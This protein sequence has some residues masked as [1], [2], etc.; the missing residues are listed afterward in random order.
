MPLHRLLPVA[1]LALL[2]APAFAQNVPTR[3]LN[4]PEVEYSE[5]FTSITGV[6]ELR[7]GR[8]IVAD[9]RDKTVQVLDLRAGSGQVLGREGS[10]PGEYGM[11]F[12]VLPMA[13]DTTGIADMLN[14][15]ILMITP[16]GR[17]G[18]FVDLNVPSEGGRGARGM[19]MVGNNMPSM[20]DARGRMYM[21]GAPFAFVNGR[22]Q[23]ADSVPL[24]RWDRTTN[25][26]DT[27][28]FLKLPQNSSSISGGRGNVSIRIGGG[29]PFRGAD[30]ITVAP[31]GRVAII[32]AD[33]YSVTYVSETGQ[34]TNGQPIRYDRV[35][36]TEGHRQE[37]REAQKG[38]SRMMMT[39][40]NGRRSATVAPNTDVQDPEDW[41]DDF[42]PPFLGGAVNPVMFAQ[43][44]H[45]WVRRTGPAGQ[46]PTY[47][48]IDRAGNLAM[49]V[50][51]PQRSR[52]VGFGNGTV[53][54][55][56]LDEDDLQY[57]QR[58]RFAMPER[59]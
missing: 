1:A 5:P 46:P 27:L 25:K 54:T 14:N 10:G 53:Y 31:D 47:D 55:I 12:R 24:I 39:N 30:Q 9:P 59:P 44:G 48:I 21:Q 38:T 8:V 43:D 33:P 36:V 51:L 40:D 35:R 56:R 3:T 45:L 50:V 52:L 2:A 16:Q 13:G 26:R 7:D 17:V 22:P 49:K 6:R 29:A 58:H 20:S 32:H 4:R 28:A 11:P 42:M 23:P 57:L 34:R 37:W 19:V 41:G 18:G 15:R